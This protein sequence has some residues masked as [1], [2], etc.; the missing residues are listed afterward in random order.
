MVGLFFLSSCDVYR[1]FKENK[2]VVAFLNESL[3]P[4]LLEEF[5]FLEQ[6]NLLLEGEQF[7]SENL[8]DELEKNLLP[9][10]LQLREKIEKTLLEKK[11]FQYIQK[12]F[13]DKLDVMLEGFGLLREGL[14]KNDDASLEMVYQGRDKLKEVSKYNYLIDLEVSRLKKE[15][16]IEEINNS[17]N[18]K[19]NN[20][21]HDND[22]H[23]QDKKD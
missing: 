23:S 16:F 17:H 12:L 6:Y 1:A 5:I 13:L 3:N 14:K 9:S 11:D 19:E 2:E 18:E 21:N 4:W 7:S 20:N 22:N 10:C 15:F 8:W